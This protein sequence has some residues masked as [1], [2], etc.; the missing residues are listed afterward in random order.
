MSI[1]ARYRELLTV[2]HD[3]VR[4]AIRGLPQD[5][6][7]WRSEHLRNS[8]GVLAAH[9]AGS[10]RHWMGDVIAGDP[11]PRDRDAEFRTRGVDAA[12]LLAGI[13]AVETY[14]EGVLAALPEG[15][16][17]ASRRVETAVGEKEV[18]VAWVLFHVLEHTAYHA[19]QMN[20]LR[21]LRRD[22]TGESG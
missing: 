11:H 6:L 13:D 22:R 10:E 3:A 8:L 1:L 16:L 20:V 18:E 19:G 9:I 7:D 12:T 15:D 4:Q 17:G 21:K 5:A 2:Q 14:T